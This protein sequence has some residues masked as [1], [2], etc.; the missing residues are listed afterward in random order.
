MQRRATARY[1]WGFP[2]SGTISKKVPSLHS[3]IISKTSTWLGV[4]QCLFLK[5]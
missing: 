4:T 1:K 5:R 2:G 3:A